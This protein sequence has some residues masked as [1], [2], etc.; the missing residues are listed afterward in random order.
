MATWFDMPKLGMDMEEGTIVKWLKPEGASV[1]AG[2]PFAEIETDKS[3][4]EVE[5]PC[6]GVILKY[7]YPEGETLEIGTHIAAL[8]AQGEAP[9]ALSSQPQ[10]H[11]Q[12]E[13]APVSEAGQQKAPAAQPLPPAVAGA[14]RIRISPRARRLAKKEGVDPSQVAATGPSGR[15]VERDVRAFLAAKPLQPPVKAPVSGDEI[16]RIPLTAMRRTI[17]RRMLES[18]TSIPTFTLEI[19]ADMRRIIQMRERMKAKG[20]R[21]SFHDFFV[22]CTASA[23]QRHPL[24]NASYSSDGILQYRKIHVGIAV[25]VDGGLVV[26]V[27]RNV[28]HLCVSE[29]AQASAALIEK[30][31]RGKLEPDEMTGGHITISNLGMYPLHSFTAIINPPESCILACAGQ[32]KVPSVENGQ[33][34]EIPTVS[35][36][37]TFD[38]RLIDGA[39]GAGFMA[40]LKDYLEDPAAILL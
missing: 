6:D 4:V 29:I 34:I 19:R 39:Y 27:L 38:H 2:E 12:E 25:A 18:T 5:A 21:T 22:R 16:E 24:L 35:V 36:T 30:A 9:P 23:M 11:A 1:K 37:A 13:P 14:G 32:V 40:T 31:R 17:A 28:D 3:T 20:I 33:L 7:Y 8:G 10:Q 15:I 26:P